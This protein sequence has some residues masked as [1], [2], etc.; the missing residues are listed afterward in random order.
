MKQTF[1]NLGY[2]REYIKNSKLIG[3][4]IIS[5]PD[6]DQIGYY[7]TKKHIASENVILSNNKKIKKGE[8]YLTR[9]YP[10]CGKKL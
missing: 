5:E 1:E 3:T 10:L 6:R 7:S 8:T 4:D 2:F 9:L